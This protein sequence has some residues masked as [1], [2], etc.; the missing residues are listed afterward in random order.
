MSVVPLRRGE[1]TDIGKKATQLGGDTD[2]S[3]V[4]IS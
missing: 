2:C 3:D 4:A 1:D